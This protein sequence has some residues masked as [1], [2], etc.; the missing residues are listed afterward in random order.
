V[1]TG[2]GVPTKELLMTRCGL[3]LVLGGLLVSSCTGDQQPLPPRSAIV[4][5]ASPIANRGQVENLIPKLFPPGDLRQ[6]ANDRLKSI[7]HALLAGD[8]QGAQ[9]QARA[10]VAFAGQLL[11][12]DRLLNFQG[13]PPDP[14]LQQFVRSLFAFVGI[15][16]LE[17][18]GAVE[19]VGPDQKTIVTQPLQR[20][21][22]RVPG[23][24]NRRKFLLVVLTLPVDVAPLPTGLNQIPPFYEFSPNPATAFGDK[25]AALVGLCQDVAATAYIPELEHFARIRIA[26]TVPDGQ[27]GLQTEVLPYV[28]PDFLGCANPPPGGLGGL[29]RKLLLPR[30]LYAA[31]SHGGAGGAVQSFSPFAA[32]DIGSV[33]SGGGSGGVGDPPDPP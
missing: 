11:A 4:I 7:Q 13:G 8:T 28:F 2:G 32:V 25:K 22:V 19:V 6:Q 30:A 23:H 16:G 33:P 17:E 26:H 10:F 18:D 27:G 29:L 21:G 14:F 12:D 31:V 15:P 1:G 24:P 5:G 9:D 3:L 20:A